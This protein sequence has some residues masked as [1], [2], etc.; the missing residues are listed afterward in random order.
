MESPFFLVVSGRLRKAIQRHT[1]ACFH[2]FLGQIKSRQI[3]DCQKL[4][5]QMD[6]PRRTQF[7]HMGHYL[8]TIAVEYEVLAADHVEG[9]G[10][11]IVVMAI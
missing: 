6:V 11:V 1:L 9:R 3:N 7:P 2:H 10:Q 4:L 8:L 5:C